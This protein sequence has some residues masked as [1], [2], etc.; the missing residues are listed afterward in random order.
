MAIIDVVKYNASSNE[1][2][3][4]YPSEDLRIGTQLVVNTAQKAIFVKG[5]QIL[6]EFDSG[7]HTLKSENIPI[8]NKLINL[9]FGSQSPFQAEV[10]YVN[11]ISVLDNKWGTQNPIQLEDPKYKII[12]P[13]RAFGQFGLKVEN[14]KLL[15]ESLVGNMR[16]FSVNKVV[17]YFKGRLISSI[18]GVLANKIISEGISIMEIALHLDSLSEYCKSKIQNDFNKYGLSVVDFYFMSVSFPEDD[19]S[20]I[21]LKQA[22]GLVAGV[23]I[24]GKELYQMERTLDIMDKA[25]GNEGAI[26]A[27][28][29][30]GLGFGLGNQI[31]N[32]V[33]NANTNFNA[34]PPPPPI[35][36]IQ[37]HYIL[38]RVQMPPVSIQE[39]KTLIDT[40]K[41]NRDTLVWKPGLSEWVKASTLS[42]IA[43]FFY[44]IPPPTPNL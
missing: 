22:K 40:G 23:N 36:T 8:L 21:K 43:N 44:N 39:F 24:A 35:D 30:A 5:G 33:S 26:G 4:K 38:E 15:L 11:L 16:E 37:Y 7:T 31:G 17:E 10:W 34:T 25:A 13:I 18:T 42:E 20:V 41:I 19:P 2:V 9:P 1:F 29:G 12:V 6:D 3:W 28:I 27:T 14:P 32:N